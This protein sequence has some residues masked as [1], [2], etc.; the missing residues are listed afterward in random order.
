MGVSSRLEDKLVHCMDMHTPFYLAAAAPLE[1]RTELA[2]LLRRVYGWPMRRLLTQY[3]ARTR[4]A[5]A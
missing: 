3:K 1:K 5:L 2:L 4:C